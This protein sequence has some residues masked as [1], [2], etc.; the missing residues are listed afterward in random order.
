MST[1]L[2]SRIQWLHRQI[3]ENRY[4]N[5]Y[6]ISEKF[7]ISHRQAQR[8]IEH[9]KNKLHAPLIYDAA[10]KGFYYA[11]PFSLPSYF[12]HANEGDYTEIMAQL[13]QKGSLG[14]GESETVQM[15]IPFSAEIS[16]SDKLGILA[17]KDFII[18]AKSKNSFICEFHN[19]DLFLGMLFTLDASVRIISPE[20]LRQKA[21]K[22]AKKIIDSNK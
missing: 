22:C 13:K 5:A 17:L 2:D 21:L 8:D 20:W 10:K 12:S 4:P 14:V 19:V 16:I 18:E 9:L 3:Y 7:D 15:Q 1:P 11:E 6:R